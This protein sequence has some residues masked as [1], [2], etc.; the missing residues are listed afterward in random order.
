MIISGESEMSMLQF[1]DMYLSATILCGCPP[2][3]TMS[4]LDESY[5]QYIIYSCSFCLNKLLGIF[6]LN[7][8]L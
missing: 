1:E 4:V 6:K 3:Y 5:N 2:G 8:L 7:W